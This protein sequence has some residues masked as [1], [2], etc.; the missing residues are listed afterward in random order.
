MTDPSWKPLDPSTLQERLREVKTLLEQA[1][2]VGLAQDV[3]RL[4]KL[5]ELE[6]RARE[7][8]RG[9]EPRRRYR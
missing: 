4:K 7:E 2:A 3:D 9:L 5:T 8:A 1:A 6:R